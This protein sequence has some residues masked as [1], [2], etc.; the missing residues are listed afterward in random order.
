MITYFCKYTPVELLEAFGEETR[1]PNMEVPD[2]SEADAYIHSSVCTHAKCLILDVNAWNRKHPDDRCAAVFTNCCDSVRRVCGCLP[3]SSFSFRQMLD[4]PHTASPAAVRRYANELQLLAGTMSARTGKEFCAEKLIGLWKMT[5]GAWKSIQE[6]RAERIAV[7][8]ARVSN[9]LLAEIKD[10]MPLPVLDLTCGGIRPLSPP[11]EGLSEKTDEE[12]LTAYAEA[13]LTQTPCPRMKDTSARKELTEAGGIKGIVYHTVKFCDYYSF[14]YAALQQE[15]TLPM[16]KIETDYTSQQSGQMST[17]LAAFAE[18]LH[19]QAQSGREKNEESMRKQEPPV[20]AGT[21]KGRI[22]VGIDSGSTTTNAAAIDEEGLL[23]AYAILRTGAKAADA[24]SGALEEIRKKLGASSD[25]IAEVVAT[26]Y[27]REFI[28]SADETVTE[29]S[30]HAKGAHFWNPDVR[31][32]IDIGGQDSKVICLD[33]NGNVSGFVMNDKC[34]A[35]TGRFLEMMAHTLELSLDEMS[36]LGLKWKKD[37]TI[38]STCTVFAESEVVSLIAQNVQ[39]GD[40]IHA[41]NKSVA[42][43]TVS[44][45]RRV[46][47]GAPFMMT[48]G[49][50]R[51][52]GVVKELKKLL[53]SKFYVSENPDLAGAFGAALFAREKSKNKRGPI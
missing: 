21:G 16:V 50:A 15:T 52:E 22:Y 18:S 19:F 34:A 6:S 48:G 23:L 20:P 37:L 36:R 44:M 13:L 3:D 14:E 42:S 39:T 51:N 8:G 46:K 53:G 49:V 24:A 33:E 25:R 30:C 7:L 47:G 2:F 26:G 11:P 41:L 40:I 38:T 5:A 12:I 32:I 4:L 27:G 35:G 29:I 45:V 10:Q 43:R 1:M 28:R 31:T 17:R 9:E